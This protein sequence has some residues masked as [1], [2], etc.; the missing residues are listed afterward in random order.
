MLMIDPDTPLVDKAPNSLSQPAHHDWP[1]AIHR[2]YG[3]VAKNPTPNQNGDHAFY[4]LSRLGP[5][6]TYGPFYAQ[7]SAFENPTTCNDWRLNQPQESQPYADKPQNTKPQPTKGKV[8]T[9]QPTANE[10]KEPTQ[11]Q[12]ETALLATA[13]WKVKL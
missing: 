6:N 9:Y 1:N 13:P 4:T 3:K 11:T 8:T 5:N 12:K 2:A 10:L 7:P